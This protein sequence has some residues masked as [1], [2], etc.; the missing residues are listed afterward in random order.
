MVIQSPSVD[1]DEMYSHVMDCVSS[2]YLIALTIHIALKI[3]LMNV[4]TVYLH[5]TLDSTLHINPS[6]RF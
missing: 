5:G 4:V 6:P 2:I 1:F 3:Y